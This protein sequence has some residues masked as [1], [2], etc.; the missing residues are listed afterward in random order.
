[1]L[2]TGDEY[3]YPVEPRRD[4]ITFHRPR[5]TPDLTHIAARR[6]LVIWPAPG[7]PLELWRMQL[8]LPDVEEA[9]WAHLRATFTPEISQQ[10]RHIV[11]GTFLESRYW[12]IVKALLLKARGDRCEVCGSPGPLEVHHLTYAHRGAEIWHLDDLQLL[13][14]LCHVHHHDAAEAVEPEEGLP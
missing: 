6:A 8:D 12:L 9:L 3:W 10:L 14:S 5:P 13:C 4:T 1:M 7:S 11:Y 2:P